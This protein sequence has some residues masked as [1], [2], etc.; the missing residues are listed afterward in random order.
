[1]NKKKRNQISLFT[2]ITVIIVLF[3]YLINIT[4]D[5]KKNKIDNSNNQIIDNNAEEDII[6][7]N[8]EEEKKQ[9][10]PIISEQEKKEV[11]LINLAWKSW[12][13][14][15]CDNISDESQKIRCLDN[16]NA[17]KATEKNDLILCE[18]IKETFQKERCKDSIY[19]E[20]AISKKTSS[21]CNKI[22]N[23]DF[24]KSCNTSIV[25]EKIESPLYK[26]WTEI[27]DL[28]SWE[29]KEYCQNKLNKQN[30]SEL[31]QDA[32]NKNDINKCNKIQDVDFEQKCMDVI[33]LKK[34]ISNKD[35]SICNIIVN[36][37]YSTQCVSTLS[38]IN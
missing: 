20:E 1:M 14:D 34:A 27:C 24:K 8:V 17:L 2:G 28:L 12:E 31:L 32:I 37:I 6:T 19:Y 21:I 35:S 7:N 18:E 33:N 3:I 16:W 36:E 38:K 30:D 26:W 9:D 10:I 25:L 11:E 22:T 4:G 13:L 29:E 15:L 23:E 5:T